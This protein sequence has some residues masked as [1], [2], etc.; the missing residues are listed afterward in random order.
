MSQEYRPNKTIEKTSLSGPR[1]AKVV[2]HAD[3]TYMGGL[4]VTLLGTSSDDF[5]EAGS[6]ILVKY[7][8]PFFGATNI[9]NNGVNRAN[10]QAFNDT[11][12][13]YGMVFVPPDVGVTVLV[14]FVEETGEGFWVG[15]IP[16]NFTNHMVPAV[17]ASEAVDFSPTEKTDYVSGPL[18]V[19]E[20]N[21]RANNQKTFT[22]IDS[23]EKPVHPIAG[24]MLAQGLIKDYTRG[25]V[26]STMRRNTISNVYGILTPGPIDKRQ[27]AKQSVIG[28][29]ND[30]TKPQFVS[31]VGGTQLV[32]DDGDD[33]FVRKTPANEGGPDYAD[34]NNGETGDARIP[35]SE[36]FRVR[37]R[38]GHQLL[39]HN[40]EDLIYIGNSRGTAWIELTSNGKI[41]IYA[42]DSVSIHTEG[43]FNFRAERDIN[44]EAKRNINMR[45]EENLY[46]EVGK[47]HSMIVKENS[48]VQIIGNSDVTING[49]KTVLIDKNMNVTVGNDSLTTANGSTHMYTGISTFIES[50]V[51]TNILVGGRLSQTANKIELNCEPARPADKAIEPQLPEE[52]LLH[53][54][55]KTDPSVEWK[56]SFFQTEET[57]KSIMKRIPMHEPWVLHENNDPE[58]SSFFNTDR[59]LKG[60]E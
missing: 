24:F 44:L 47:N 42:R 29:K 32:M 58:K 25:P 13:S 36:Y 5:A 39:M 21:K 22:D 34:V 14:I 35:I 8:P 41:D 38:T 20:Y 11:Q 50:G 31:R 49:N 7:C 3:N 15:C 26:T 33:R 2:G 12:K 28:A 57:V 40:S 4:L 9:A 52:L 56:V 59:D 27:G 48:L 23:I 1:L 60:A 53:E 16:D 19:A 10:D 17:A 6:S 46:Q 45:S 51:N 18:P 55:V 43:D 54:N 37:T 30:K